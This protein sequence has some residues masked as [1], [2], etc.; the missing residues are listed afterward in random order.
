MP[1]VE[2]HHTDTPRLFLEFFWDE[3]H[4]GPFWFIYRIWDDKPSQGSG[5]GLSENSEILRIIREKIKTVV[6]RVWGNS[7][8]K[9]NLMSHLFPFSKNIRDLSLGVLC[10]RHTIILQL[11]CYQMNIKTP[12]ML[13]ARGTAWSESQWIS[14]DAFN[15]FRTCSWVWHQ[16]CF[17]FLCYPYCF[18]WELGSWSGLSFIFAK[19]SQNLSNG[20]RTG[21]FC[22]FN[23]WELGYQ[24]L[25]LVF[26]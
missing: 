12:L 5:E 14:P 16:Q 21:H 24:Y 8:K 6:L 4:L 26:L 25:Y 7:H 1:Y 3:C 11:C 20:C 22:P 23:R 13:N 19:L 10:R 9:S 2:W 15:T 18:K 17:Y